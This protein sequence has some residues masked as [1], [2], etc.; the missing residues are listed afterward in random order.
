MKQRI[1]W[2]IASLFLISSPVYAATYNIDPSHSQVSFS[3]KHLV[4]FKVRGTFKEFSGQIN[5]DPK[6]GTLKSVQGS[7]NAKSIDTGTEKR[8]VH[9]R[10]SDFFA[11]D[12]FSK[13]NFTSTKITGRGDDIKVKGIL[14]I[15]G[16]KK[17][18]TL[19]G[20]FLGGAKDPWGNERIGFEASA[21]IDRRDFG[22]KYNKA[23]ETG[24]VVV[25]N[26]VK[27]QLEVEAIRK[28]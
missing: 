1:F 23:L 5:F 2:V 7:V 10:N 22:L 21:K 15:R 6:K 27:I 24:G 20:E 19:E 4:V 25:G 13:I 11:V 8:D 14:E 12:K 18:V 3:I 28:K 16:V 26:M 17:A 9:L